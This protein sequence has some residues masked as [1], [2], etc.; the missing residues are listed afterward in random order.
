[1]KSYGGSSYRIYALHLEVIGL[2]HCFAWSDVCIVLILGHVNS[3]SG[4]R[5]AGRGHISIY[6]YEPLF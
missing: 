6:W 5:Q 2:V 3:L 1:M 4:F